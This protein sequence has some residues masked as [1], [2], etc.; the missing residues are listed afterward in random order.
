MLSTGFTVGTL[1]HDLFECQVPMPQAR[2]TGVGKFSAIM[3]PGRRE[4]PV[5]DGTIHVADKIPQNTKGSLRP[6]S[7]KNRAKNRSV[8]SPVWPRPIH[9]PNM[10]NGAQQ[11][12][13][14][15]YPKKRFRAVCSRA[16]IVLAHNAFY[17]HLAPSQGYGKAAHVSEHRVV[18]IDVLHVTYTCPGSGRALRTSES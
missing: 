12:T 5:T 4:I 1:T 15:V 18:R 17:C 9:T 13:P 11:L 16:H 10:G 14:R 3:P 2:Y 6:L 8:I 7:P